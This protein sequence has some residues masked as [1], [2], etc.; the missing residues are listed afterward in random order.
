MLQLVGLAQRLEELEG[1]R[2]QQEGTIIAKQEENTAASSQIKVN[3]QKLISICLAVTAFKY[4]H[5][6]TVAVTIYRY[7]CSGAENFHKSYIDSMVF[8]RDVHMN[9]NTQFKSLLHYDLCLANTHLYAI[10]LSSNRPWKANSLPPRR[11][12][13]RAP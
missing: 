13:M 9:H 7:Y 8:L 2:Q 11:N 5:N 1:V 6:Y 12:S 3:L 10:I 4:T